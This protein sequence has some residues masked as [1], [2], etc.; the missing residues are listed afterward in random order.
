MPLTIRSATLD[1]VPA[2]LAIERSATSAAHWTGEQYRQ[3]ISGGVMLVAAEEGSVSGFVCARVVAGEWEI[4][5]I[6]V[7]LSA[8]RRGFGDRLLVELLH[9]A[10]SQ[11]AGSIWL[12]VRESN[13]AAR[14][15]YEKHRFRESARRRGYYR[16]PEEDALTYHLVA[17]ELSC[18]TH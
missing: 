14:S 7:T 11:A 4:E 2:L 13:Q 17:S 1:D 10:Q 3:R 15:L 18:L 6:V 16:N 8:R 12:E 9:R 5:N